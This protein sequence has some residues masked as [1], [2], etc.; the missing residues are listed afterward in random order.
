MWSRNSATCFGSGIANGGAVASGNTKLA[1][2]A[3]PAALLIALAGI[4]AQPDHEKRVLH[5]Y[6]DALG[7]VDTACAGV[8]GEGVVRG[9]TYTVD[10]CVALETRYLAR[11]YARMGKC[12]PNARLSFDEAKAW[13]HFA[14]NIG[15][16]NFCHSTAAK[17]LNRGE[18]RAACEQIKRWV[19]IGRKDC[20]VKANKCGGIPKRREWEY[21]TCV[22]GLA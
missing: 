5:T 11:M 4:L 17:L 22:A 21:T 7:Q 15:E 12:V 9:K 1:F 8:T 6:W 18:N 10:E 2:A 20:R 13:G 3:V 16:A 14:Y 19:F